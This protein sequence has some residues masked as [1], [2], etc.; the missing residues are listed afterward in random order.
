MSGAP[1]THLRNSTTIQGDV[2]A[3]FN[4]DFRMYIFLRFPNQANGRAW[5]KEL[6]PSIAVTKDVAAF[7]AQ[8]SAA[9]AANGGA[10]PTNL[11]ATWVNVSL[12]YPGMKMLF[13]ADPGNALKAL[14]FSSFVAGPEQSATKNG[15]T[16]LSDP[17]NW[18]VGRN[19]QLIHALLNIQSDTADGLATKVQEQQKL[20]QKHGLTVVFEQAGATLSGNMRGHEHFGF[21]DGI[22]QPGV[23]FFDTAEPNEPQDPHAPLGHVQGHP[24]TEIIQAGEFVLG[25]AV[26]SDSGSQAFTPPDSMK[27]MVDGSF[28]VFRRLKQDVPGFMEREAANLKTLPPDD[29]LHNMLGA[30]LV[31][32]WKSGSPIDLQPEQNVPTDDI[33]LNNFNFMQQVDQPTPAVDEDGLRCPRFAHIRK[34]YPRQQN[35][36]GNRARRIIRRGVPFGLSFDPHGGAGH[37]GNSE[38]GLVFVAYMSSI[39]E[40]FEFLMNVWANEPNFPI[41]G[42][43]PDPI[44]GDAQPRPSVNTL[45]RKNRPDFK[46][47]FPRFVHTTGTLYA[48]TPSIPAL[49]AIANGQL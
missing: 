44:I 21:K 39:E 6:L 40:K 26:E 43:G 30:K 25:Q 8:F 35:F 4:K 29:P 49:T 3:G 7:N 9:R 23:A 41:T 38:R 46:E 31:G 27:W 28:Q 17:K 5:L 36:A 20:A 19:N 32:R 33:H 13:R 18:H 24:G 48:F 12:T 1:D 16:L 15:D 2:L 11:K 45:V 14:F 47:D 37:D 42:A 10:D 34:V 22:S